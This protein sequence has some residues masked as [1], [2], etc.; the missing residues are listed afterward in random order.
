MAVLD[1]VAPPWRPPSWTSRPAVSA[2]A[3]IRF[4][5]G[6]VEATGLPFCS[7]IQP[8]PEWQHWDEQ[9]EQLHG[10]SRELLLRHGRPREWVAKR[11][12]GDWPD[13]PSTATAGATITAGCPSSS[14]A[15]AACRA[16]S[17]KTCGGCSA[18]T[19]RAAGPPCRRRCANEARLRRHRASADAKVLQMTLMRIKH[20]ADLA[21]TTLGGRSRDEFGNCGELLVRLHDQGV[22]LHAARPLHA[23]AD[24][25]ADVQLQ[26]RRCGRAWTAHAP[27]CPPR[28]ARPRARDV[29]QEDRELVA[30]QARHQILRPQR[31]A[32]PARHRL[33]QRVAHRMAVLVVDLLEAVQVQAEKP[34][35]LSSSVSGSVLDAFSR[36][37][38]SCFTLGHVARHAVGADDRPGVAV[39]RRVAQLD[40]AH[41]A[42]A[43]AVQRHRAAGAERIEVVVVAH[44]HHAGLARESAAD[45]RPDD[46]VARL[47]QQLGGAAAQ[48]GAVPMS[49]RCS[50]A[51]LQNST[52]SSLGADV[53]QHPGD[54][55]QPAP[56]RRDARSRCSPPA[57]RDRRR[58]APPSGRASDRRARRRAG[59]PRGSAAARRRRRSAHAGA[60]P[61]ARPASGPGADARGVQIKHPPVRRG[62]RDVVRRQVD[63]GAQ[64]A[65]GLL[66]AA[67]SVM[68]TTVPACATTRPSM[69]IG[70]M[71]IATSISLPSR[72][73]RRRTR[74]TDRG[75]PPGRPIASGPARDRRP[76]AAPSSPRPDGRARPPSS[77]DRSRWR[78]P[79]GPSGRSGTGPS[80]RR[81]RWPGAPPRAAG[82]GP[83]CGR[84]GHQPDRDH[85]HQQRETDQ[86]APLRQVAGQDAVA[87]EGYEQAQRVVLQRAVHD[88]ALVPVDRAGLDQEAAAGGRIGRYRPRAGLRGQIAAH[89]AFYLRPARQRGAVL[90]C[91]RMAMP[92]RI[93]RG[94]Y[95][96]SKAS[97]SMKA[98]AVSKSPVA[99]LSRVATGSTRWAPDAAAPARR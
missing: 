43:V 21:T 90:R 25:G 1:P 77:A 98:T 26:R 2:A 49:K 70:R 37:I 15:P 82:C 69:R 97:R 46:G 40:I 22:D 66:L 75:W 4:E 65:R 59:S 10:I 93:T 74:S 13:R 85:A 92:G 20:G 53:A 50:K 11:S 60:R 47:A 89:D 54:R 27:A 9:A 14:R 81:R 38:C 32:Q 86:R 57:D 12:T 28:C 83:A 71:R 8:A 42:A 44:L 52:C 61:A 58:R 39:Q 91:S 73:V 5:I 3:A 29:V 17:W 33:E 18:R 88:D 99:A 19:R 55:R 62:L 63:D 7:L 95:R 67:F 96:R 41:L 84:P 35:R 68:S 16:S 80:A 45:Q 94:R 34:A 30:A 64:H 23:E 36:R 56:C 87:L 72:R 79:R 31:M 51:L 76:P 6:F 24:A 48:P 78:R